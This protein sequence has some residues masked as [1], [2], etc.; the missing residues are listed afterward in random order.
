MSGS[1]NA[2]DDIDNGS[3]DEMPEIFPISR[4]LELKDDPT[5]RSPKNR[6]FTSFPCGLM[7]ACP[8]NTHMA[9]ESITK[10]F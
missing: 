6:E 8:Y 5:D 2:A 7:V 4:P 10:W 1:K 9:G 3:E